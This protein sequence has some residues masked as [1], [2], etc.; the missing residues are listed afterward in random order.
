M[1]AREERRDRACYHDCGLHA[2]SQDKERS[3]RKM[4]YLGTGD[5]VQG[6]LHARQML[7]WNFIFSGLFIF[8]NLT[9]ASLNSFQPR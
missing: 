9:Q 1:Q 4:I 2:C 6:L 5:G 7:A 8:F 3:Q